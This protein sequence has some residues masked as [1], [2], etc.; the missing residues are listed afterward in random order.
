MPKV[1]ARTLVL[2]P[3]DPFDLIRWLARSQSD[4]R[5]A[6]AELVQ[7][8]IDAHARRVTIERRRLRGGPALVVR[9]DGEGVLPDLGRE[10]ALRFIASNIG[11][12]RKR[13]L[14][15]EERRRLVV[16]GQYGVGLLGFW[17]VGHR[18][19]IRSRVG[20][21]TL[22]VLRLVEDEPRVSLDELAPEIGAAE[23]F[24]EIVV[25]ELHDTASRALSG[26]RLAEYLAA[27]LRGPILASGAQV[28]IRDG[29]ARGLAQKVFPVAPRPFTGERLQLPAEVPVEGH[30]PMRVELYLARGA[31]RPAVQVSCAGTLV[32][33]DVGELHALDLAEAPW[34]GCELAGLIE[35]PG[36]TVPPGS[37][38]GVVPDGAAEAFALAMRALRPLVE[39]ELQRLERER[40]AASDR[41]VV[42]DLRRAL[43]GLRSRLPQYDLPPVLGGRGDGEGGAEAPGAAAPGEAELAPMAQPELFPAGP[44]A[45]ARIVPDPVE[46]APGHEHRARAEALDAEGRRIRHGVAFRW[47]V[48]GAGFAVRGEGARPAVSAEAGVRPGATARLRV[49]AEQDGRR[50]VAEAAIEAVEPRVDEAGLGIP[51]PNLVD[52]PGRTWRSRFDGTRWEVNR[53]HEDYLALKDE[54]RARLRYLLTLLAKDLAQHAHRVPGAREASEDVAAILALAER[55]LRGA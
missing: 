32:A 3:A 38:R 22:H 18:M 39:A 20:G 29:M 50:A 37:R 28:E 40:R 9:D 1:P 11:S 48:E 35:F 45:A 23:T 54:G 47:S 46:V 51:E 2:R 10:E 41:Q 49:E 25:T 13:N 55:N 33:D 43:R 42:E 19:E 16:I 4:P 17:S 34:V 21:S 36:F 12:S 52:D 6:V 30:P 7:N 15:P 8:S 5:K 26:R 14:S 53:M 31:E 24:T 27:E 44:L